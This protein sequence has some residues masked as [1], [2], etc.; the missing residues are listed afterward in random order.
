M[1]PTRESVE[2]EVK[3]VEAVVRELRALAGRL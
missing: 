2:R 1:A 3:R